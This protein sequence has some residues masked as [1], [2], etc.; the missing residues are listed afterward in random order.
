MVCWILI[1][2]QECIAPSWRSLNYAVDIGG[3]A[4]PCERVKISFYTYAPTATWTHT[5]EHT[6]L[7]M[8]HSNKNQGQLREKADEAEV[9]GGALFA[10]SEGVFAAEER[11]LQGSAWAAS[12]GPDESFANVFLL[13]S[14]V[15][16]PLLVLKQTEMVCSPFSSFH[17]GVNT[18]EGMEVQPVRLVLKWSKWWAATGAAGKG[19]ASMV[20]PVLSQVWALMPHFIPS[21]T[22]SWED[23]PVDHRFS[24]ADFIDYVDMH[25]I[26]LVF[27]FFSFFH[28]YGKF[29]CLPLA[30]VS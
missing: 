7:A 20:L 1:P 2:L 11:F 5:Q 12:M 25:Q 18:E 27:F 24:K 23:F 8:Y 10:P 9:R 28:F 15:A 21:R 22:F 4:A 17:H 29:E 30:A 3:R 14:S 26:R 16:R 19:K 6:L 13:S